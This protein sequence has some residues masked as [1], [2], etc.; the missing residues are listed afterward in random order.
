MA[1]C[2]QLKKGMAG[3]CETGVA[4]IKPLAV[5]IRKADLAGVQRDSTL[6]KAVTFTLA[7][8][9]KGF[10]FE[11]MG[12]SNAARA[13]LVPGR[14]GPS[15]KHEFDTVAF[16]PGP[17]GAETMEDLAADTEGVVTVTP[18]NN[19]YYKV[20][21]LNNGLRPSAMKKDSADADLGGAISTTLS[22]DK[23]K[24]LEDYFMV[25]TDGVYDAAATKTAF[26]ALYTA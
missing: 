20:L 26:E 23:E 3:A 8:G 18:D 2:R 10:L 22:S 9:K 12:D 19:G 1:S 7:A 6:K 11:G 5:I 25:L 4:G 13:E 21:G 14:Y 24:G 17:A 15:Y 16:D